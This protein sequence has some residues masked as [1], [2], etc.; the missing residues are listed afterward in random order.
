M[1]HQVSFQGHISNHLMVRKGSLALAGNVP[2]DGVIVKILKILSV[3]I[4]YQEDRNERKEACKK[5]ITLVEKRRD[6]NNIKTLRGDI[7]I[8]QREKKVG[9]KK[10]G[11][12][13]QLKSIT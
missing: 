1:K 13:R 4:F 2:S 9:V 11:K 5:Q 3:Q 10:R 7:N 12:I 6:E 8:L